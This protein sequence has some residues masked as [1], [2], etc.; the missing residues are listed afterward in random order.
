[1]TPSELIRLSRTLQL[2]GTVAAVVFVVFAMVFHVEV[3][4]SWVIL[5]FYL[6]VVCVSAWL[7]GRGKKLA[8]LVSGEG[9]PG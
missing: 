3:W 6:L 1:M 2:A 8:A 7:R 5:G 4:A 9:L